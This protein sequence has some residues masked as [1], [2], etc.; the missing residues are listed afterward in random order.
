MQNR[1]HQHKEIVRLV[2][3]CNQPFC[4]VFCCFYKVKFD[5]QVPGIIS[6]ILDNFK[7]RFFNLGIR[8]AIAKKFFF[9]H[10]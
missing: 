1:S 6:L 2:I 3:V 7:H 9:G 8:M 4:P 10:K 5:K